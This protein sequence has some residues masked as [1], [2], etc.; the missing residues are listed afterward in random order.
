MGCA[1]LSRTIHE[2]G[3]KGEL[4]LDIAFVPAAIDQ[5]HPA[6]FAHLGDGDGG[7]GVA[8]SHA[9]GDDKQGFE[10]GERPRAYG[11]GVFDAEGV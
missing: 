7:R 10:A 4:A 9:P 11:E 2:I 5:E 3:E 1:N 6:G 8:G